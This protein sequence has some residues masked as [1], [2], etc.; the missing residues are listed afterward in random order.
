MEAVPLAIH[1]QPVPLPTAAAPPQC[2]A[3]G[4]R[5]LLALEQKRDERARSASCSLVQVLHGM[6]GALHIGCGLCAP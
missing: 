2:S 3:V 5:L 4:H 6:A 1:V